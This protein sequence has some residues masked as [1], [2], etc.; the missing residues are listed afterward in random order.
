MRT[1]GFSIATTSQERRQ[2]QN[3]E[4][5][6]EEE[7]FESMSDND[8]GEAAAGFHAHA[9]THTQAQTRSCPLSIQVCKCVLNCLTREVKNYDTKQKQH[10]HEHKQQLKQQQTTDNK[11]EQKVF[12]TE[13]KTDESKAQTAT[14]TMSVREC[15]RMRMCVCIL[16]AFMQCREVA[17]MEVSALEPFFKVGL[18]AS[19]L[20]V[21]LASV[22]PFWK[23][24][25]GSGAGGV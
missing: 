16:A 4:R 6:T 18:F 23:W 12:A 22:S 24:W 8:D 2:I 9:N 14:T 1:L 19:S 13:Q 7:S 11:T 5:E 3:E 10:K 20:Y 17:R 25:E 15:S 21:W